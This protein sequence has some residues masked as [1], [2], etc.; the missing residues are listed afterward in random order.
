MKSF[1]GGDFHKIVI[2]AVFA[3]VREMIEHKN[4]VF[5]C[6]TALQQSFAECDTARQREVTD[7]CCI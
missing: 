3:V 1:F 5:V 4:G 6:G 2:N 7:V